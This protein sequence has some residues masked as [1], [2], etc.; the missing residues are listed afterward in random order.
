MRRS[1]PSLGVPLLA[2]LLFATAAPGQV[3]KRQSSDLDALAFSD[4]R[5]LPPSGTEP[6][7]DHVGEAAPEADSGWSFFAATAGGHWQADV[8]PRNGY[9][10]YV[11]GSGLPWIP[12]H[13]NHLT[14]AEVAVP[15]EQDGSFGL[16]ALEILSRRFLA[17]H[18]GMLGVD[19]AELVL[20]HSRSGHPAPQLWMVDFDVQRGG[21][22]I[23]GARVVFRVNNGNLIQLGTENLP[24]RDARIPAAKVDRA[25]A[26][27]TLEAYVGGFDPQTDH[28]VDR[29]SLHLLPSVPALE[30]ST[31]QV[32]FG[33]GLDLT[34][35]WQLVLRRDGVVGTWRARV[36]AAT[37][38]LLELL[39]VNEYATAEVTGGAHQG[40]NLPPDTIVPMPFANVSSGGYTNSAGLYDWPGGTVTSTLQGQYVRITDTCG[41]ISQGSDSSG[42]ILFDTSGGTDCTTPG[43][44]GSGNTHA[45]RTQFYNVNR[46]KEIGRGW[47]PTNTWL[48]AQLQVRVNLNQTCNAYW[49]GAKLNFFHSGGGCANTGELPG[50]SLH[51]W[52]HGM[53]ANDGNGSQSDNGS[54]ETYG[55]FSAAL[56][57]HAS[58]VGGGFL[59]G[60]CGGY[61]NACTSCT[62]VRDIDFAHHTS[63]LPAT[64]AN[65]TQPLC[66]APNASNPTYVG[67]CGADVIAHG[68]GRTSRRE[69]H[70]ESYVSSEALWDFAARDLPNPGSGAAW[71]IVD[72]LWY[73]SRSTATRGFL[74]DTTTSTW[75]SNGC[76]TGTNWR[77]MRAADDDDGNLANGTPHSCN[78]YAAFNRHGIACTT[79]AGANTCFSGCTPP[80][81][82]TVTLAPGDNQI[83]VSWSSSGGGVLYDVYRNELGCGA[84]FIRIASGLSATGY[85][86]TAVVNGTTYYYQVIAYPTGNGA[87]AAAPSSCVSAAP[88][89]CPAIAAPSGIAATPTADNEIT[90][91]WNDSATS[92][93]TSYEVYRSTV[94]GGPYSLV[95]TV[96]DSG[97]GPWS[98]PDGTVSGGTTYYY[99]VRTF[100]GGCTAPDS[101][102]VFATAT[103]ACTALP[104]FAGL[105]SV[106]PLGGGQ[107][108]GLRLTW[109]A[110]APGCGTPVTYTIYRATTPSFVPGPSNQLQT[111]VSGT[112]WDD[113][114]MPLDTTLY[115]VAR[116]EDG[117]V[118]GG[119]P[120]NGGNV[121]GNSVQ[122]SALVSSTGGGGTIY[123]ND[124]ESGV[125]TP[126][127]DFVDVNFGGT[128]SSWIGQQNCA[129]NIFRFGGSANCTADYAS[130]NASGR[131]PGNGA[132]IA[133]PAGSTNV[134]LNFDHRW[135]FETN[136]GSTLYDGATVAVSLDGSNFNVPLPAEILAGPAFTGNLDASCPPAGTAGLPVWGDQSPNYNAN[137]MQ[138]TSID[139][140]ALCDDLSGGTTGCAGLTIFPVWLG[141]TDCTVTRDG[142]FVDN[143]A[144]TRDPLTACT[145]PPPPVRFLTAT[146][147]DQE[148]TV[149]WLDPAGGPFASTRLRTSTSGY[150]ADPTSGTLLTDE[151]GVVGEKEAYVHLTGGGS[152]GVVQY[153]SAFANS[154]ANVY[155]ARGTITGLPVAT[156]GPLKWDFSTPASALAPPIQGRGLGV[157]VP[158]NDRAFYDLVVGAG[159]GTWKAGYLPAAMNAPAQSSPIVMLAADTGLPHDAAFVGSQDGHVYC[160]NAATGAG[161]TGWPAGGRSTDGFGMVQTQP[162]FDPAT[163]RLLFGSRNA[164]GTNGFYAVDVADGQTAWSF[165]NT[166]PQGGD[167]QAMGIVSGPA[168]ILGSRVVFAS[169]AR[170]GGSAHTLWALDFGAGSASLAWSRDLGDIDGAPTQDWNANHVVVGTN[171]GAVFALDPTDG[172]TAWTRSF[173][174][175]AVKSFVYY[176]SANAR[177][178]FATA[179]TVWSIPA[180]GSTGDDWSLSGLVSPTRP[181]LHFGT[182]RTYLGACATASCTDGRVVELDSADGW[183]T[184]KTYDLAGFGGL[185]PVT[186]DRSQTPALLHAGSRSGRVVAVELPLP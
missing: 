33:A 67:P 23:E 21:M 29:G 173:G 111:C 12:G 182:S 162:M 184:P 78:L 107:G 62:G 79:D 109:S 100:A 150:P 117:G 125:G 115:Y 148:V 73:L 24:P 52:G 141:I 98:Y 71:S 137:Q 17:V 130:N 185:G 42:N 30:R 90:V 120:C 69:G 177:L 149:E 155:S 4:G 22:I 157:F 132:G 84:G 46:A 129:G 122:K 96:P 44:G 101:A 55:D 167:G 59:G 108:C 166:V 105:T 134:R 20:S 147:K 144:I 87:C 138:S 123:A 91:S 35:V 94:S 77:T 102:E 153:Y 183:V 13:G 7:A 176:D 56:L 2:V 10:G 143:V 112:T 124:F 86:D 57:T 9:V 156:A 170:S 158:S 27:A 126:F 26:L 160:F 145:A 81:T 76:G 61:G 34:T 3:V 142:W 139:L 131:E 28:W 140:D 82:P 72:R 88:T 161:C 64:V 110:A 75:T 152:N 43:H 14:V 51:E 40:D 104:G 65:F 116:A 80:S 5:F 58:C 136:G 11:E 168:L 179:T 8:D 25:A 48:N 37:G 60:N 135:Q 54:G 53:D 50:V 49:D 163:G 92:S 103:G 97:A 39:D 146:G 89:S 113:T 118:N 85:L 159:G 45:T 6:L 36:D 16:K 169:R 38:E 63:G 70:C 19:P 41:S 164:T 106:A 121:E 151:P 172:S 165:T 95:G 186:I 32:A 74:C 127:Y 99:V 133:V 31:G 128:G 93:V 18:G 174:D 114:T 181:I 171:G 68:G 119:G 178:E 83:Q 66:P 180:D 154:G 15:R 175:S 47:L 1:G